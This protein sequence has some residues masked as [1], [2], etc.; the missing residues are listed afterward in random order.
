MRH[1]EF[2]D[3]GK[4]PDPADK[5]RKRNPVVQDEETNRAQEKPSPKQSTEA[6]SSDPHHITNRD[7]QDVITNTDNNAQPLGEKEREGV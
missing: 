2:Q 3:P 5:N 4:K 1:V 7:E 6:R